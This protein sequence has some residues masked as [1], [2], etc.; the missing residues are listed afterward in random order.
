MIVLQPS[1]Q[2]HSQKGTPGVT[3]GIWCWARVKGGEEEEEE[4]EEGG[5]LVIGIVC[6]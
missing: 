2:G 4:E 5:G 1:C 3:I 6:S